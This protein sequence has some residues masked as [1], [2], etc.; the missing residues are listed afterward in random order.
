MRLTFVT[1]DGRRPL[2]KQDRAGR[3]AIGKGDDRS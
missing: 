2:R 1:T 3:Q